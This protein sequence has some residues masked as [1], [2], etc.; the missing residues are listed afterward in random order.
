[1]AYTEQAFH[2]A[3]HGCDDTEHPKTQ[4]IEIDLLNPGQPCITMAV[5]N[6]CSWGSISQHVF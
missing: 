3:L 6:S 2:S 1:M 4:F 5:C